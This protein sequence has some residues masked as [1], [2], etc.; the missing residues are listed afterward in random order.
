MVSKAGK[1]EMAKLAKESKKK[2]EAQKKEGTWGFS[3]AEKSA[4]EKIVNSMINLC[5]FTITIPLSEKTRNIRTDT[6]IY[7]EPLEFTNTIKNIYNSLTNKSGI[8]CRECKYVPY[9]HGYWYVKQ[10]KI[11]Y[12]SEQKM[13]LTLSPLPTVYDVQYQQTNTT[14][15]D[16]TTKTTSKKGKKKTNTKTDDE[17]LVKNAL[18]KI[19]KKYGNWHY[20]LD[21]R[22]PGETYSDD[23]VNARKHKQGDCWAC[24]WVLA[25]DLNKEGV[26]TRIKD[27]PTSASSHHRTVQYR[28]NKKWFNFPYKKYGF[29]SWL[30][31]TSG[32]YSGSVL[33]KYKGKT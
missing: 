28:L 26:T 24:S 19:G 32:V 21:G 7:L 33:K 4:R 30:N 15:V 3:E 23:P 20:T 9:R 8:G 11:D 31:F 29:H 10:V 13:T 14:K 22:F 17:T 2:K 27:Y 12:G 5:D 18:D 6:F 25:Q 16:S 1:K